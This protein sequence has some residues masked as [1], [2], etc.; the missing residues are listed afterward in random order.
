MKPGD[1]I[2]RLVR[3]SCAIGGL[4]AL[5]GF[6]GC[7]RAP[8]PVVFHGE[9]YPER[10]SDWRV[11]LVRD[12]RLQLNQG[13]VPYD[14]NTPLFSD[15]AHKLRTIWMP[16]G[17][18]AQ[19]RTNDAFD[20][21]VGTIISKTFYYPRAASGTG[22]GTTLL[23][24]YDV[25]ADFSG[26]ALALDR[27]HL[28]ETRLLVRRES[29]WV[30]LPYVWNAA[31]DDAELARAGDEKPLSLVAADGSREH[32][33]YVVPN[34]NQCAGCHATDNKA[35]AIQ[36]IGLKARHLNRDYAYAEG[37]ENQLLRLARVGY[38]QGAPAPAQAPRNANW[39]DASQPLADRARAYLDINCGHCHNPKGPANTSGL[40]L[41]MATP[42][43]ER[44]G[45][46]KPP[47]AAG[48]GTGDHKFDLVPG[49]P[50]DSIL[51]YRLASTDPGAMMP[52]LGRDLRHEDGVA[53]INAWI[54]AMPGACV[55]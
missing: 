6:L 5:S 36:P 46:C 37:V 12:D 15:Y 43:G 33:T 21:P 27:V 2:R 55:P 24:N 54:A 32:F 11:L 41:D 38:L 50:Q 16:K 13:V 14:L 40:W 42:F 23:R 48:Q 8:G 1:A 20:F 31:Q 53:L 44:L 45:Y 7:A 25:S 10:L 35:R 39:R 30:A 19:Y 51:S 49:H 47:V 18:A 34:A 22:D 28:V 9:G 3:W 29:G 17:R 52:E 26:G 4:L